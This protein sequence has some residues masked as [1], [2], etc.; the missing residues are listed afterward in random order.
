MIYVVDTH[1]LVW[2]LEGNK[3]LGKEAKTILLKADTE[4]VIPS[5]VLAECKFLF[6]KKR[7]SIDIEEIHKRVIIARNSTVYPLDEAVIDKMPTT[8]EIHDAIIVATGLVLRE[9]L[10]E[11]AAVITRDEAIMNA[12]LIDT[13]W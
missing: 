11:E 7:I 4:I 2:F 3:R 10:G 5:I 6:A 9:T 13:F 12:G 1:A 8:L